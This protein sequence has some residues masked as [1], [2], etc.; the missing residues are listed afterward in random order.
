M[1]YLDLANILKKCGKTKYWLANAT[2]ISYQSI[3]NLTHNDLTGI[4]FDTLDKIC[5]ALDVK[6]GDLIKKK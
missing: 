6:P 1:I 2:E 4:K 3:T 5:D